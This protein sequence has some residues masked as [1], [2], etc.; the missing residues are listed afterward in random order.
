MK[1]ILQILSSVN[2]MVGKYPTLFVLVV[3]LLPYLQRCSDQK[4]QRVYMERQSQRIEQVER[5]MLQAQS[6]EDSLRA[7]QN[8]LYGEFLS[9]QR[10]IDSISEK[11]GEN[12][13]I[14]ERNEYLIQQL[15][16]KRHETNYKDSSINSILQ[17]LPE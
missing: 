13:R 17:Y 9:S 15:K 7:V 11:I 8:R 6:L 4:R 16:A 2:S 5:G 12:G 14:L 1:V 3:G 10:V